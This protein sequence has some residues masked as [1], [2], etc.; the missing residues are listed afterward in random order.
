MF[1]D[2]IRANRL[3]I[4]TFPEEAIRLNFQAKSPGAAICLRSMAMDFSYSALKRGKLLE[5]YGRAFSLAA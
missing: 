1:G 2:S 4:E 5:A 3:V